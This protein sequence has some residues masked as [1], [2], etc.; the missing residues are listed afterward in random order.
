MILSGCAFGQPAHLLLSSEN[1]G[2]SRT[3][4]LKLW[5]NA[6]DKRPAGLQWTFLYLPSHITDITVLGGPSVH[7]AQK[8]LACVN[9][10]SGILRCIATG[11]NKNPIEPGVVAVLRVTVAP[12]IANAIIPVYD[13]LGVSPNGGGLPLDSNVG[14]IHLASSE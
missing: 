6:P 7:A 3:I 13:A 5:L 4:W 11:P 2:A 12:G 10:N 8:F 1:A 14:F 9:N